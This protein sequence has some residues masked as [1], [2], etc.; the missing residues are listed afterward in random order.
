[1]KSRITL[2]ISAGLLT[3]LFAITPVL[4]VDTPAATPTNT[5]TTAET[6]QTTDQKQQQADR[7]QKH[8]DEL[9]IK[10]T[11]TQQKRLQTRCKGA[12]GIVSSH[13]AK[14]KGTETSRDEVY[15]NLVNH[16]NTLQGKLDQK[17]GDTVELKAEITELQAKINTFKTDLA[18]YKQTATDLSTMDCATDPAG[19]KASLE[20]ARTQLKKVHDDGAAIKDYV[21]NTVKPTLHKIRT[22]LDG[23]TPDATSTKPEAN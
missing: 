16:F 11:T 5:T 3:P 19:F 9:K 15:T 12:Q 6:T 22:S 20:T 13:G 7:I 18:T 14:I 10:L 4:A 8:K 23:T 1:M 17:G 2:A 21:T